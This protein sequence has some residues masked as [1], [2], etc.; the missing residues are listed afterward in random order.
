MKPAD[1]KISKDI[2][3]LN[4]TINPLD[5]IDIKHTWNVYT[6]R[7]TLNLKSTFT[8]SF[9]K[10]LHKQPHG[11]SSWDLLTPARHLISQYLRILQDTE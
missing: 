9:I 5:P 11:T 8:H 4:N 7:V 10:R 1:K 6:M 2:K 3:D